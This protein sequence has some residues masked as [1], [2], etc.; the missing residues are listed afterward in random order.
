MKPRKCKKIF[1]IGIKSFQNYLKEYAD[2]DKS[3]DNFTK[4]LNQKAK[5]FQSLLKPT[6]INKLTRK[7]A[8]EFY[9]YMNS[10]WMR[11]YRF[12]GHIKFSTDNPIS[13]IRKSLD[14]LLW[15][16]DDIDKRISFLMQD[17]EYKLSNFGSSNIQELLGWV[18]PEL[19]IRNDKAD[20]AVKMLGFKI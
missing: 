1:H 2:W 13:K 15:S 20:R 4:S 8:K 5:Y 16:S 18:H 9:E 6:K 12:D 11:A 10:G 17:P 3:K 7:Q 19:P 14:Y